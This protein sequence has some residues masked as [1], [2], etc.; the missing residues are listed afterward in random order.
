METFISDTRLLEDYDQMSL[1]SER[2]S[3]QQQRV[4]VR[5]AAPQPAPQPQPRSQTPG[6]QSTPSPPPP[7]RQQQQQQYAPRET[8]KE[9]YF[10][11]PTHPM[12][13]RGTPTLPSPPTLIYR[14]GV[15]MDPYDRQEDKRMFLPIRSHFDTLPPPQVYR[16]TIMPGKCAAGAVRT[17]SLSHGY[18]R[19]ETADDIRSA[20]RHLHTIV[21]HNR[22]HAQLEN[23]LVL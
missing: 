15:D 19:P 17:H 6:P 11:T 8:I 2:P 21:R 13:Y 22:F 7:Q 10:A 9:I 23:I 16:D 5:L 3:P 1:T 12:A 4:P 18:R 20:R 14:N